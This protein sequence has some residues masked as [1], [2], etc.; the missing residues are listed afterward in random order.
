MKRPEFFA[1]SV[2][3]VSAT[4]ITVSS[5]SKSMISSKFQLSHKEVKN[6]SKVIENSS[7]S[8]S[9]SSSQSTD[10]FA[11]RFD[12][13]RFIETLGM[14]LYPRI[15]KNFDIKVFTNFRFGMMSW[16][17][18]VV[19]YCIKQVKAFKHLYLHFSGGKLA[20]GAQWTM[21]AIELGFIFAG[22]AWCG[23]HLFTLDL[24][25]TLSTIR[26]RQQFRKI[27]GK[28]LIWG[29]APSKIMV[30]YTTGS[31]ETKTSLLLT[32]GWWDLAR[33]FHYVPEILVAFFW[34]VSALFNHNGDL[35]ND[36]S[37]DSGGSSSNQNN[38]N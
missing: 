20:T 4:A 25:C 5:S 6:S 34:T 28:C 8:S 36:Q 23:S 35:E 27:H 38:C 33:H 16:A 37:G 29:K 32:S 12:G 17:V 1:A 15:G 13:L 19:T 24:A 2:A 7:S 18:L 22:D 3:A 31:R 30:S 26:Q 10:Q 11:P 14:E 9:S 21:H